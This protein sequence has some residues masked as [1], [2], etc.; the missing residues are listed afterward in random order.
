MNTLI[1]FTIR[2]ILGLAFGIILT[3]LF[4]PDWGIYHGVATGIILVALAYGMGYYRKSK[5]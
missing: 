1:I 2:L 3:R 5:R 4:K